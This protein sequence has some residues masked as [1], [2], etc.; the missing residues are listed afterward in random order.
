VLG[1][2]GM[3]QLRDAHLTIAMLISYFTFAAV[4]VASISQVGYYG[5]RLR[6]AGAMLVKHD[7]MLALSVAPSEDI[8]LPVAIR[9]AGNR[10]ARRP[11]G[12]EIRGA[13]FTY[14]GKES[15][16]V[17]GVTFSIPPGKVTAIV[18]ESGSGKSTMAAMLCG[19]YQ[20]QQGF[21]RVVDLD[22]ADTA[23]QPSA[24]T[25]RTAIVPQ[26]PFLFS[27]TFLENITFGRDN[28]TEAQ[29]QRA[30]EAARIHDF[31]TSLPAGYH[32]SLEEAGKNLSR[33]QR[34]RVAIARALAGKPSAIILDEATASLDVASERAIKA[35]IDSLRGAV[36]FV[37][38]AHQGALLSGIDHCVVLDHG[39][40]RSAG[41]PA[42]MHADAGG[43]LC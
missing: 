40:L 36:T 7:A 33:G 12:F 39:V 15:P 1:M 20:P 6:Q 35:T 19:L 4:L 38:I 37:I 5:G 29:A 2:Y 27:G 10:A 3:R 43:V 24:L 26:E 23:L 21:I 22:G 8:G 31:I 32:T 42:S 30:A 13:S 25:G 11:F 41:S 34:Q 18:G 17:S 28:I 16:A 14:P 9:E